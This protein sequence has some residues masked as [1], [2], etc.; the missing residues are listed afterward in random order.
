MADYKIQLGVQLDSKAQENINSQLKKIEAK[1]ET[2]TLSKNAISSI[3]NQLSG[4][5]LGITIDTTSIRQAQNEVNKLVDSVRK[6][7]GLSL[8]NQLKNNSSS[9]SDANFLADQ[10]RML[11]QN[12]K[13]WKQNTAAAK[14]Y[15][16]QWTQAFSNVEN[17]QS[18]AQL[19]TA[20]KQINALKAEI[21]NAGSKMNQTNFLADQQKELANIKTYI[22]ANTK[23]ANQYGEALK[24]AQ[25]NV[26]GAANTQELTTARKQFQAL[27]AEISAAGMSGLSFGDKLKSEISNLTSFFSATSIILSSVSHLKNGFNELV[28]L[29]DAM[30]ELKKVTDETNESYKNFYYQ[31]NDMAKQLGA[32]TEEIINQTSSWAQLGYSMKDAINLAKESSILS[33]ISPEMDI[34]DAQKTL[35]STMKAYKIDADNVRDGISSKINEIGKQLPKTHYIG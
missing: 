26:R 18:K 11:A 1:I 32:T 29:D 7:S 13:Y 21:D 8:G 30:V 27:K 34:E 17:A 28:V 3:Q 14:E 31:A 4:A 23:A 19:T 33:T 15:E 5:N 35:V 25:T 12:E 22:N 9:K 24:Q 6:A 20:T 2:A 10:Q 16:Q